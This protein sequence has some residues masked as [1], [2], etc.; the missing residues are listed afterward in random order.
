MLAHPPL[1]GPFGGSRAPLLRVSLGPGPL[2]RISK[3]GAS[4]HR[5]CHCPV[6]A[7][8]S[9][10]LP[11]PTSLTS[12]R[13]FPLGQQSWSHLIPLGSPVMP[14]SR[15]DPDGR[16]L[17]LPFRLQLAFT[18]QRRL[19]AARQVHTRVFLELDPTLCSVSGR[20]LAGSSARATSCLGCNWNAAYAPW[21]SGR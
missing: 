4:R 7:Q 2:H 9:P 1:Q 17:L 10:Q 18:T 11:A 16:I 3:Y 8:L 21:P 20:M 6:N 14:G 19:G 12:T 5:Q 13:H 15:R